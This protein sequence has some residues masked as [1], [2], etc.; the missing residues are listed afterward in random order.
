MNQFINRKVVIHIIT[1]SSIIPSGS[2]VHKKK[3]KQTPNGHQGLGLKF[4]LKIY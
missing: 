2:M 3:K 1:K 4:F